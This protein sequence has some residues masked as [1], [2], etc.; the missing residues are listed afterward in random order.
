MTMTNNSPTARGPWLVLAGVTSFIATLALASWTAP[1]PTTRAVYLDA[2]ETATDANGWVQQFL[3]VVAGAGIIVLAALVLVFTWRA[4]LT[5]A[6]SLARALVAGV[7]V[8]SAYATSEVLKLLLTQPRP[9]ATLVVN[10]LVECPASGDWSL[11]SNH[12]AIAGAL[13]CAVA[14]SAPRWTAL[15]MLTSILV[16]VARVTTGVHYPHD[17]LTGLTLGASTVAV[18]AIVLDRPARALVR[19]ATS[20][21][22][23]IA[24]HP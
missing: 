8:V 20:R 16:A 6:T 15:A 2:V 1:P 19:F 10:A 9:C 23:V 11:P 22:P 21:W 24:Q 18:A 17:V 12:A 3:G 13:A 4:L 5:G 7:G 14:L